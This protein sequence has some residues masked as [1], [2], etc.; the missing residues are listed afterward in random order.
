MN[1]LY[2]TRLSAETAIYRDCL[3][4]HSLPDIFHYWSNRHVRP[5]LEAFGF[6][7]PV[8]MFQK[9][10]L[11]QCQAR[12]NDLKRFVSIGS[13]NC[14]LEIGLGLHL[15]AA[16]YDNFV[17]DCVDLN[18][19]MLERGRDA[20]QKHGAASHLSFVQADFNE[21]NP[22]HEYDAVIANQSLHHVLQLEDLFA[23]IK[24]FLKP[25]GSFL[26]SDMIGRN[27]HQRWPEALEIVWEF[28]RKLP[29]SYRFNRKLRRY[30]ELYEN[31]DCS[32]EGFEGIRSQDVLPL[33]L[34]YFRFQLFIGFGNVIDPFV[35]RAFGFNFDATKEWDRNFIDCVHH[36]DQEEMARGRI[37][38]T[39]ILAVLGNDADSPP[40]C[41][42][43]LTPEFCLRGEIPSAT[44]RPNSGAAAYDWHSWPHPAQSEL[45]IVCGNLR[46]AEIRIQEQT[47]LAAQYNDELD[48]RTAWAQELDRQL[49]ERT[50]WALQLNR[51]IEE[52]TVWE[53]R[54][55]R[56]LEA[57]TALA[58]ERTGW[59]LQL[60]REL[61]ERTAWALQLNQ[62]IEQRIAR[63]AQLAKELEQLSWARALDR[64]VR[65]S[66]SMSLRI[67]RW[68][69]DRIGKTLL[70][71]S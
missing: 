42:A 58:L 18:P 44:G 41:H 55:N 64:R 30:E 66:L 39:H 6:S 23:R 10:L 48:R 33:L 26:V 28:W 54:L 53:A 7:S 13:G 60:D 25:H 46:D 57:Q 16:G 37:A 8:G 56:A 3:E 50:A 17:I 47:A 61:Q 11:E 51:E 27:G 5:E 63:E 68:F 70:R 43:P 38:P 40:A 65:R 21:W 36:R 59:A 32:V 49:E 4:V 71:R 1:G 35:D 9:F 45:E 29:P 52:R 67:L 14:D 62:E 2:R 22:A 12:K 24:N 20:A 19:D 34:Q 15:R 31:W 69:R